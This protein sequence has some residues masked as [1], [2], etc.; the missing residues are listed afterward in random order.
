MSDDEELFGI[1]ALRSEMIR[2]PQLAK[3]LML[4]E[5]QEPGSRKRIGDI[6]VEIGALGHRDVRNILYVQALMKMA[7]PDVHFMM[8]V[9]Q[10]K[11]ASQQDVDECFQIRE[12]ER[13]RRSIA[14]IMVSEGII[15]EQQRADLMKGM[16]RRHGDTAKL[17]ETIRK[18]VEEDIRYPEM[19]ALQSAQ[20]EDAKTLIRQGVSSLVHLGI[21]SHMIHRQR[22]SYSL[23]ELVKTLDEDKAE[24]RDAASDLVRLKILIP[25]RFMWKRLYRFT[26]DPN[27]IERVEILLW[28]VNDPKH[29]GE[30]F[31]LLL[32]KS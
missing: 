29:R 18:A 9:I 24:I 30:M 31:R 27:M 32:K 22:E 10:Q 17:V 8:D 13:G 1:I 15:T 23:A 12:R 11:L 2:R 4:Q 3:A 28:S 26:S 14:D 7:N 21:I 20:L 19:L 16:A 5:A 25:E 6:L